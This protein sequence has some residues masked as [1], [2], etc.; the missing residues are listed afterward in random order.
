MK[1]NFLIILM[2]APVLGFIGACKKSTIDSKYLD[3]EKTTEG[4]IDAF[5][6]GMFKNRRVI[7]D[8]WGLWTFTGIQMGIYTQTLGFVNA[9]KMYEQPESYAQDRWDDFYSAP[10]SDN[11]WAAPMSSYREI[12]KAYDALSTDADK[13]GY[14]LFTQTAKIFLYD[15]ATQMVDLW[16]D[17]PFSEAGGLNATGSLKL[18]AFDEGKAVYDSAITNLKAISNWLAN[19]QPEQ[20]YLNKLAKQDILFKG[21]LLK[22]RRYCNSLLLRL[23]MRKSYV[24][25]ANSKALV[26]ELMGNPTLYPMIDAYTDN[27]EIVTGGTN[28]IIDLTASFNDGHQ[29]APGYM[30]DSLLKPTGDPRLRILYTKNA[31]GQYHGMITSMTA[32]QQQAEIGAKAISL[33]D[34]TTFVKNTKFPGIIFTSAETWFLKAEALERWPGGAGGGSAKSAYEKG[35]RE[36][37]SNYYKIHNLSDYGT[38]QTAATEAEITLLLASPKVAYGTVT[39]DNLNKIGLQKWVAFGIMQ[40]TQS[41]AEMRR[42]GYP[43]LTFPADPGISTVPS[44]AYRLTYPGNE[45][46]LNAENYAK[47]ADKDLPYSK[48][49]W[50]K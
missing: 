2:L 48:I 31:A 10:G 22:W 23:A 19:A 34:S 38:K 20:F 1:K 25:E 5:Y 30:V 8:Y 4:S 36:S 39:E 18:A 15:Q 12:E 13:Q 47:V 6:T 16:G 27:A 14:L 24:D 44:P 9:N 40:N 35:I 26:Q 49:F 17:I 3:P 42:S 37:I 46:S 7:P 29:Y 32:A 45:R 41:W 28:L 50:M 43:K 21:D 33:I 11:N